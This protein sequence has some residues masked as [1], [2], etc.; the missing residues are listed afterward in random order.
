MKNKLYIII[1]LLCFSHSSIGQTTVEFI[2]NG[3]P[4]NIAKKVGLR[5][6]K[7]PLSWQTSI[8]LN[9]VEEG[10]RTT[11]DFPE[12][13]K[14]IEFKFVLFDTDDQP[15]WEGT[16]NRVLDL[17][18]ADNL[19]TV[20]QWDVDQLVDIDALPELQVEELMADYQ[21]VETM[22]LE[23]HPGTYRYHDQ[24]A[25][26]AALDELKQKF[27][28]PLTHGEAYLAMSK[29]T[30]KLQ[31]DHTKVGFNNQNKVIN[32]IIHRQKNK[33]PFT[34]KWVNRK[35]IVLNDATEQQV[36]A[37]GTEV[38][39]INGIPAAT[40]LQE[41]IPYIAADGA[42]D[43]SRVTNMEIEGYDFRYDP[44]DVFFPLLYPMKSEDLK[45]EIRPYGQIESKSISVTALTL[46]ERTQMLIDRYPNFPSTRDDLWHFEITDD[47]IGILTLNSFGLFGWKRMTIDYKQF[48]ADAFAALQAQNVNHLIV[49]IREN[50]GGMD[51]MK[52]EL[53]TYF[54]TKKKTDPIAREGRTRYLKFPEVLKPHVQTWGDN[55]WFFDLKPNRVDQEHGYYIF[56]ESKKRRKP[57]KKK[58][59]AFAGNLYLLTSP[60][61][62]SLAFYLAADFKHQ[63]L[64]T[65]IGQETG[66]NQRDINGG[67]I[68]FLR[69]PESGI[70][71]DFPVMGGFTIGDRPNQGVVPDIEVA[72]SIDDI[73]NGVDTEMEEAL[74]MIRK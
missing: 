64:G 28:S 41:M 53:F 17:S 33:L 60:A 8:P 70:E 47:K 54:A 65:I 74:R 4:K 10:Y 2:V 26:Q 32:S 29:V 14:E 7:A 45:L 19:T 50:N 72:P 58:K 31:C 39:S 38:Q 24:E 37:R 63:Q 20:N 35:M 6:D 25:I 5:G 51:E 59:T 13:I 12:D 69:L 16:E 61:N 62:V 42:T 48:L 30:A 23:V 49:D 68:L 1:L 15:I 22:V 55:P 27:Q 11:L 44:F 34:F 57:G 36:L 46:E 40:I 73:F 9:P 3:I 67:Q 43:K 21:L 71:I 56:L 52:K 18:A 66:G